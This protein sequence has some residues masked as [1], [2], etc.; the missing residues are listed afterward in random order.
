MGLLNQIYFDYGLDRDPQRVMLV[1][2]EQLAA[3]PSDHFELIFDH[4]GLPFQP[5]FVSRVHASSIQKE[6]LPPIDA[7]VE[8]LCQSLFARLQETLTLH[9]VSTEEH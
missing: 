5:S 2:Y 8:A 9:H 1:N 6:E 4:L 3:Q 7:G